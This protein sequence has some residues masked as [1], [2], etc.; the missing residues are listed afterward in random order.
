MTRVTLDPGQDVAATY[1]APGQYVEVRTRGETGY[2]VLASPPGVRPWE[3]VMRP[4]G[5]ASDVLLGPAPEAELEVTAAI[6][7]G[8]PMGEVCGRPLLVALS[9]TGIAAGRPLVGRRIADG[10]APSTQVFLGVRNAAEVPLVADLEEWRAAGVPVFVCVSQGEAEPAGQLA[11]RGYV[12]DAVRS[13]VTPGSFETIFAVGVASMVD[14]LRA[15][16]PA[17][18]VAPGRVLTNH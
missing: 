14:A 13:L 6:G 2:F 10:D 4:G 16:A 9:G 7:E 8:F 3:L 1:R 12:Q 11:F 15:L 5:G 18:G 17:L